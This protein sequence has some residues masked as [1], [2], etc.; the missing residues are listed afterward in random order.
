MA[1]L[2]TA[3]I[4]LRAEVGDVHGAAGETIRLKTAKKDCLLLGEGACGDRGDMKSGQ[5]QVFVD[6]GANWANTL[7]MWQDHFPERM[8]SAWEVYAFE[9][10]PLVQPYLDKFV[11][12][13]NRAED[14]RPPVTV[15]PSGSSNHLSEFAARYGCP[16]GGDSMRECMWRT[17]EKQ[18]HALDDSTLP[19]LN[20]TALIHSRMQL[21]QHPPADARDRYTMIPAAASNRDGTLDLGGISAEQIIRGGAH[22]E[23]TN[24]AKK[25]TLVSVVDVVT[26]ITSNFKEE[27]FVF[28]KMDIEGAEFGI[29]NDLMS[30]GNFG[31]IDALNLECHGAFGSC[32]DLHAKL[33]AAARN[34]GTTLTSENQENPGWDSCSKPS[35]YYPEDPRLVER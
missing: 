26:W 22:L 27:D 19:W 24:K 20:D 8:D 33:N 25:M 35:I 18:L 32:S 23:Q 28:V 29:L 17:F 3:A 34:T 31:L 9:A 11:R 5:R 4:A 14:C 6:L 15:P 10:S 2:C 13:L 16:V 7:R 21:A 12:W 30:M 1:W